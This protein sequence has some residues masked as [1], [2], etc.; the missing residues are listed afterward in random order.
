MIVMLSEAKYPPR[1]TCGFSMNEQG[2]FIDV[3]ENAFVV[4]M[5]SSS[6]EGK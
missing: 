6:A 1:K 4:V 3:C 5:A 2:S